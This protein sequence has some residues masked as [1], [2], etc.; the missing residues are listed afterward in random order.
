MLGWT[1]PDSVCPAQS[2]CSPANTICSSTN[3]VCPATVAVT[4]GRVRPRR[5]GL[6]SPLGS[7]QEEKEE[8]DYHA[9]AGHQ[10]NT[11]MSRGVDVG[12]LLAG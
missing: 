5:R 2:V 8:T 11:L 9:R 10:V 4:G 12:L 1:V 3:S 6:H 7:G